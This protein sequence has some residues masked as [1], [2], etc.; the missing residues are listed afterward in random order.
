MG[1][2]KL[3]YQ[4]ITNIPLREEAREACRNMNVEAALF[5][6]GIAV[7]FEREYMI[8]DDRESYHFGNLETKYEQFG[9]LLCPEDISELIDKGDFR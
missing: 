9:A 5:P 8:L 1:S 7:L 4:K 2:G 6:D 3:K